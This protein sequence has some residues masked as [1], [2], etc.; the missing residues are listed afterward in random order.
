MKL[1]AAL[2]ALPMMAEA[3]IIGTWCGTANGAAIYIEATGMGIG[4]HRVCDYTTPPGAADEFAD[5][6][7][8]RQI[9]L[10][11]KGDP[12]VINETTYDFSARR[13]D[14]TRLRAGFSNASDGS[15]PFTHDY[16]RCDG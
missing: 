11:D 2:A 5:T 7:T 3:S 6:I 16:T 4:E 8:C 13:L 15:A 12:I 14:A 9:Y 10:D 1:A